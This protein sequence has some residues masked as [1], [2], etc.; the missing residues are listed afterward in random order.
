MTINDIDLNPQKI[1]GNPVVS[2]S[3][4]VIKKTYNYP[5]PSLYFIL[6]PA[7][8]N[9]K[10]LGN[11]SVLLNPNKGYYLYPFSLST[12]QS[13]VIFIS[14]ELFK[15]SKILSGKGVQAL[16]YALK[17][18]GKRVTTFSNRL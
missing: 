9:Y 3:K 1:K 7:G 16:N 4:M 12:N 10:V 13:E 5:D 2:I 6:S 17:K 14:N 11:D 15:D 8:R 18:A